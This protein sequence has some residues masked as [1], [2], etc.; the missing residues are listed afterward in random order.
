MKIANT[1]FAKKMADIIT[2]DGGHVIK[3]SQY[4]DVLIIDATMNSKAQ[5]DRM[6]KVGLENN[7]FK[8]GEVEIVKNKITFS[9]LVNFKYK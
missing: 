2:K 3:A 9:A 1:Q 5:L 6:L 4:A 7:V 8:N